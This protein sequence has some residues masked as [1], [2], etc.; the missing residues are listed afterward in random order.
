MITFFY[1]YTRL[2]YKPFE[3]KNDNDKIGNNY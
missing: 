2:I 1:V 3:K